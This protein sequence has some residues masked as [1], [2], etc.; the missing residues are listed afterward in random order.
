MDDQNKMPEPLPFDELPD[1]R[2]P[3]SEEILLVGSITDKMDFTASGSAESIAK[4]LKHFGGEAT[5]GTPDP[6][7]PVKE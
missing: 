3:V 5:M 4:M 7:A 1:N 6:E 2:P